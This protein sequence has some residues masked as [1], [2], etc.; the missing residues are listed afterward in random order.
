MRI[1]YVCADL[2]I[3]VFGAKGAS[4]HAQEIIRA[5]LARG[6]D[7]SLFAAKLGGPAPDD[8]DGLEICSGDLE[9]LATP[10]ASATAG[11]REV[12]AQQVAGAI[13][14]AMFAR[15]DFDLIYERYSLWS[16]VGCR[17]AS[18]RGVPC[19][20][21][22]NAPLIMEQQRHR[23][24]INKPL[25]CQIE[26]DVFSAATSIVAVSAE[27]AQYVRSIGGSQLPV[28]VI[29]NGVNVERFLQHSPNQRDCTN[30]ITI[31]FV[32]TLKPWHGVDLLVRAFAGVHQQR[33]QTRLMIVGDGP[34]RASLVQLAS[35]LGIDD[36]IVWIG[37]VKASD[38][39]TCLA[40]FDIAV[41]PY[42]QLDGFYFS[43]LKVFEYM[44]GGIPV[45]AS[46]IG[47]IPEIIEDGVDG[48]LVDAGDIQ[49][50]QVALQYL[51]DHPAARQSISCRAREKAVQCFDWNQVLKRIMATVEAYPVGERITKGAAHVRK[52]C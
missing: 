5:C 37:T 43:P 30:E 8:F 6:H 38:I 34:M 45:V 41:A 17:H 47:Q 49:Q 14:T 33:P 52:E 46:R 27:V 15:H 9:S 11:E 19:I 18:D 24:L 48:L 36:A 22:V 4:I 51:I 50:L 20:I 32:G 25:A 39:P 40:Q 16:N 35:E 1:A 44:A 42:P 31:G 28:H 12:L 2:G 7:V 10:P 26:A 29:P 3:P 21:E 23:S 13:A